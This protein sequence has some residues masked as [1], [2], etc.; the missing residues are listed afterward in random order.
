MCIV[1]I[2]RLHSLVSISG[3]EDPT[4]DNPPAATW[5]SVETNV[6]IICSCL[7]LLRPLMTRF[8]PGALSSRNRRSS[9]GPRQYATIGSTRRGPRSQSTD[10][11]EMT[12]TSHDDAARDIQV[13][14]D[15]DVKVEDHSGNESGWRTPIASKEWDDKETARRQGSTD[16]LIVEVA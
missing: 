5:S 2:L 10:V 12:K 7:P 8:L 1:S 3:S 15:I 9:T 16:T 13:V 11:M 6:G 4:Y 14:T